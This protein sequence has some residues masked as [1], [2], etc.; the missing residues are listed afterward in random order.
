MLPICLGVGLA[1]LSQ[2]RG[3]ECS[4][5]SFF[6]PTTSLLIMAIRDCLGDKCRGHA[7]EETNARALAN[8]NLTVGRF[9]Y[10][11]RNENGRKM[12]VDE[13]PSVSTSDVGHRHCSIATCRTSKCDEF[14][15]WMR[16][17][18]IY[19]TR[20]TRIARTLEPRPRY[21]TVHTRSMRKNSKDFEIYFAGKGQPVIYF[22]KI[23]EAGT[24]ELN[25]KYI[26]Y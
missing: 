18:S 3:C 11:R 23:D 2:W 5:S 16:S 4:L 26:D 12:T 17:I 1:S 7:L 21:N 15:K 24:G 14:W 19:F 8:G 10:S 9:S 25:Y 22:W 13:C 20:L 6:P